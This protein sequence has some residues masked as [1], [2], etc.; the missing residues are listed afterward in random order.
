MT[1]GNAAALYS[2][3]TQFCNPSRA[4]YDY[5]PTQ[6]DSHHIYHTQYAT[7][8]IRDVADIITQAIRDSVVTE[9]P[10]ELFE[11]T[12]PIRNAFEDSPHATPDTRPNLYPQDSLI[13][14]I[15]LTH[16][17]MTLST[18]LNNE[19]INTPSL[20]SPGAITAALL[21]E[22]NRELAWGRLL[23]AELNAK[24]SLQDAGYSY[25]ETESELGELKAAMTAVIRD[26]HP[27]SVF[28]IP[29][30]DPVTII[31]L[32]QI[33]EQGFEPA[34]DWVYAIYISDH[35]P[36]RHAPHDADSRELMSSLSNLFLPEES[37]TNPPGKWESESEPDLDAVRENGEC[38]EQVA[39]GTTT[40]SERD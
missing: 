31:E 5:Q 7:Y 25:T 21:T 6:T 1:P 27:Y 33:L 39:E 30:P 22:Y 38:P 24:R 34:A 4:T 28:S 9:Y 36:L 11:L 37:R 40:V 12:T 13:D 32:W 14:P 29:T 3:L 26:A 8:Q 20:D 23:T 17:C 18:H 10:E 2:Q 15:E 16:Q 35:A 19:K